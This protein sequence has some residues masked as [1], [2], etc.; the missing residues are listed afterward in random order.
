MKM[1]MKN[2][3][4]R[5]DMPRSPYGHK[6]SKYKKYFSI[7][8]LICIKQHLTTFEA[9]F[10]KRSKQIW[11]WV[12]K[13][14]CLQKKVRIRCYSGPHFFPH[15]PAFGLNTERYGMR[16]NAGKMRARITPN[17]D[18]F[19]QWALLTKKACNGLYLVHKQVNSPILRR[20]F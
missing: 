9:Q 13:E 8:I 19:T 5:Y 4:H 2:G 6:Y 18:S 17:T 12:E 16:K 10:M 14:L 1:K 3:S 7:K 11:S 15:F 20:D